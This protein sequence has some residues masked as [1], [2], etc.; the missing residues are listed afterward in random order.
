MCYELWREKGYNFSLYKNTIYIENYAESTSCYK[1]STPDPQ[2][3]M[4]YVLLSGFR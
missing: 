3:Q 4:V 1:V 2:R